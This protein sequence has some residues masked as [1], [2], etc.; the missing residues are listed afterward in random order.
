MGT[1][2]STRQFFSILITSIL[3][4][5][6]VDNSYYSSWD[7]GMLTTSTT[8]LETQECWQLLLLL[9]RLGNVD[10]FYYSSWDMEML[11][12]STTYLETWEC[13]QL[14][15]LLLRHGNVDNF[16][17]SS[18]YMGMLTT[19]TTPL[20]TWECWQL[21]ILLLIHAYV[22]NFYFSSWD[23]G[24]LTLSDPSTSNTSLEKSVHHMVSLNI[25]NWRYLNFHSHVHHYHKNPLFVYLQKSGLCN[26]I[27][28][29]TTLN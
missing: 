11:T 14:L 8:P 27:I 23:S 16:Y 19:S 4:I 24:M 13:W 28:Y 17:Y 9:L 12:N 29:S 18:W 1:L 15:L 25:V 10:N 6:Y 2:T 3:A 21:L 20:E 7:T 22:G 26:Q 5:L